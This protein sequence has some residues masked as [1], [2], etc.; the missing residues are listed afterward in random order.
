MELEDVLPPHQS[1]A[2]FILQPLPAIDRRQIPHR[3]LAHMFKEDRA[4][5][6]RVDD[7]TAQCRARV[8]KLQV[9]RERKDAE[10]ARNLKRVDEENEAIYKQITHEAKEVKRRAAR[11]AESKRTNVVVS[12]Q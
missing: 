7:L 9:G 4:R 8:A 3:N 11:D 10:S 1:V 12:A 2:D 6:K 5:Q